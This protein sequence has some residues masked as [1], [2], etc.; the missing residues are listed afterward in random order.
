[1]S[2]LGS[3]EKVLSHCF[4]SATLSHRCS[5]SLQSFLCTLIHSLNFGDNIIPDLTQ[6]TAHSKTGVIGYGAGLFQVGLVKAQHP[7]A[8]TVPGLYRQAGNTSHHILH[9]ESDLRLDSQGAFTR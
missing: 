4:H 1:M 2:V 5:C 3:S 9:S 6:Q 7:T 8:Q